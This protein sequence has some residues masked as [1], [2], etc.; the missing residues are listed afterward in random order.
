[1]ITVLTNFIITMKTVE[2]GKVQ[3]FYCQSTKS[4][5]VISCCSE[6]KLISVIQDKNSG[7]LR[8]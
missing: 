5:H 3:L 6:L 1:M 2:T 4:I 8:F 7:I